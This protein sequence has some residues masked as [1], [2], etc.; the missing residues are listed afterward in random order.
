MAKHELR[1][2][3]ITVWAQTSASISSIFHIFSKK[4]GEFPELEM[5]YVKAEN[6][7]YAMSCILENLTEQ[8]ETNE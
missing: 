7:E 8:G 3:N 4:D 6:L 2:N 5:Q 1:E